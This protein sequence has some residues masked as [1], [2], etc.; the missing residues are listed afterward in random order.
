M[1]IHAELPHSL[2]QLPS[3]PL[4]GWAITHLTILP[5]MDVETVPRFLL[6]TYTMM[7]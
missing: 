7:L 2:E 4:C 6:L 3:I 1:T 5:L